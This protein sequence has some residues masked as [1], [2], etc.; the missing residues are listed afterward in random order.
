VEGAGADALTL[1]AV[2]EEADVSVQTIYN[3]VGGRDAVLLAVAERALAANRVYMDEAYA[4]PGSP[5]ERIRAAAAAY[6]MFAVERPHQFRLLVAPPD[7]APTLPS[8]AAIIEEQ[9]GKL[10][11]A[12]RDGQADGS[13]RA[14]LDAD[15][16]ATLLWATI[17]GVLGLTWNAALHD[18]DL[19][20]LLADYGDLLGRAILVV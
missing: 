14:D 11:Q 17:N 12:I 10:A 2:S 13:M 16:T 19:A 4:T 1:P 3:R 20:S 5:V 15:R 8:I 6:A 7:V 9:N 18:V